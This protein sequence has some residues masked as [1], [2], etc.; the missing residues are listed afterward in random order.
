MLDLLES[1]YNSDL[2]ILCQEEE[3]RAH[4]GVLSAR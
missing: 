2:M 3:I 1:G 4:R